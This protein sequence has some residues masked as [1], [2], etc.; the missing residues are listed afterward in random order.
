MKVRFGRLPTAA[1]M[2]LAAALGATGAHAQ[3][4]ESPTRAIIGLEAQVSR[5]D[6]LLVEQERPRSQ[7][8]PYTE[9]FADAELLYRLRDYARAAVLFTDIVTNYR[10]TP[11]YSNSLFLLGESLYQAGDRLGARARFREVVANAND[12]VFRPFVQRSLGRLIEIALRTGDVT[13]IEEIFARLNQIPPSEIEAQTTYIRGKYYFFRAQPDYEQARQAFEAV[14]S[15]SPVYP[16]ARYFLGAILTAQERYP[17]AIEAFQRVLR[18]Q[19]EGPEQEQVLD[20]AALAIG[21]LQIERNNYDGAIEAYQL[22]GRS[23]PHF[24]RAL[25][26][27]AWAFIRTGD[28]IRAERAL[29]IL[30]ISNPD[31]PLI[32][33]GKLLWGNLLLRTGRFDRAQQVFQEVRNQFG[34]ISQQL[35]QVV[36]QNTNP[37][38]YFQQLILSNIQVFDA[39]SFIPQAA[40]AW[41]RTEGTLEDSLN[42][43]A[44]LNTCRQYIRESEDLIARLNAAIGSPS[45]AHI[46]RDLRLAREQVYQILN[47]VTQVRGEVALALDQSAAGIADVNLQGIIAQRRGL[48]GSVGRLPTSD[49]AVR[50]RDRAAENEFTALSQELQRNQQRVDNLEAM[51]VAIERYLHTNPQPGSASQEALRTE[52]TQHRAAIANYRERIAELRRLITAGRSQ[53]GVGDP[54]YVRDLEVGREYRDLVQREADILRGSGRLSSDAA[55]LLA[56]LDAVE[57]RAQAFDQRVGTVVD[58]RISVIRAQLQEEETRVAGYRARLAQL[59]GEASDVVGHLVMQQFAAVRLHFYRIVMRADLGLVDVAWEQRE[60]HNN[61][62]R[63][64]AEEENREI[65]ALNDEFREVTEGAEPEPMPPA[66]PQGTAPPGGAAPAPQPGGAA[67]QPGEGTPAPPPAGPTGAAPGATAPGTTAPANGAASQGNGR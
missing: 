14:P 28:A 51:V 60:E 49:A 50:R 22:V 31:S 45:R 48:D 17:E 61:R 34:P 27:Q 19:P 7:V 32:P 35:N 12:P 63:L 52:L 44:D 55:S 26:E 30:A 39:S 20:L 29:E 62:A 46:F 3:G 16:Q 57:N 38:T 24:D 23:S 1:G 21:R 9:R 37:E 11:A 5:L 42:V 2:F 65:A 43:V 40:L 4:L 53:V 25:F 56:R 64:L 47:R 58:R 36:A 6:A 67:P 66:A 54:R 41:V 15:R 33:E 8:A 10:D 59:E 13:G 18:I